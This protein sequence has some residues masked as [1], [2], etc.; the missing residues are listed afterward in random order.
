MSCCIFCLCFACSVLIRSSCPSNRSD[1]TSPPDF[2][3]SF[4]LLLLSIICLVSS[5]PSHVSVY[6]CGLFFYIPG[7][8][9]NTESLLHYNTGNAITGVLRRTEQEPQSSAGSRGGK[10]T[11]IRHNFISDVA[12]CIEIIFLNV[13]FNIILLDIIYRLLSALGRVWFLDLHDEN[14]IAKF[15]SVYKS[16]H[17]SIKTAVFFM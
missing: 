12:F 5:R 13:H 3:F 6:L 15:Y 10:H 17:T 4:L 1:P 7:K 16:L 11:Q 8:K 2:P 9:R 14:S